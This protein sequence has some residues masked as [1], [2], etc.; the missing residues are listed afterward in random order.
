MR[1]GRSL[2]LPKAMLDKRRCTRTIVSTT[3]TTQELRL[4]CTGEV[5]GSGVLRITT[6][7][8]RSTTGVME[9]EMDRGI[10]IHEPRKGS[11]VF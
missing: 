10:R 2:S 6:P 11:P 5:K 9:L 4:T 1:G 7:T 8:P 3:R